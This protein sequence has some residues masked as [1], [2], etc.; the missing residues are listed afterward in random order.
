MVLIESFIFKILK[1]LSYNYRLNKLKG[2]AIF[3]RFFITIYMYI[4]IYIF[5]ICYTVYNFD[6]QG[7]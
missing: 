5:T 4:C 1:A 6:R 7:K 3:D 2:S